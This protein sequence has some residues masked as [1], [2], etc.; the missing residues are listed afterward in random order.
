M[1]VMA[2]GAVYRLTT[3]ADIG[4]LVALL[5]ALRELEAA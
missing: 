5:E 2:H 1:N 4:R 3:A